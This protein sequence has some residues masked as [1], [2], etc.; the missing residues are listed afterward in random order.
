[1]ALLNFDL[2][3]SQLRE[4]LAKT[5]SPRQ[6]KLLE[7][8]IKHIQAE[9]EVDLDTVFETISKDA[10]WHFWV[11]GRDLGP[12]GKEAVCASYVDA[13]HTVNRMVNEFDIER[14]ILD[15]DT[16][17]LEGVYHV[18]QP[19][20]VTKSRGFLIDDDSLD[21][22]YLVDIRV[23]ILSALGS[24]GLLG[25]ETMYYTFNPAD[26]RKISEDELPER[27]KQN[28]QHMRRN[29]AWDGFFPQPDSY[30]A[31]SATA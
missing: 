17:V 12:K 27:Y 21:S 4:R 8:S 6:R 9:A 29:E 16:L 1:M 24:D 20:F 22:A 18:L 30:T 26:V 2:A 19:G 13:G 5:E 11:D 25:E 3:T 7:V 23:V 31:D 14:I 10:H 28:R 15:E